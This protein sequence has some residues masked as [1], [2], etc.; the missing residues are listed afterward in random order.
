MSHDRKDSIVPNQIIDEIS[1][2]LF[3]AAELMEELHREY[4]DIVTK[5]IWVTS[6]FTIAEVRK[7]KNDK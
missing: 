2:L 7:E 4:D 3:K 1:H 6:G 5:D